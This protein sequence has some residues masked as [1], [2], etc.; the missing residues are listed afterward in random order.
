MPASPFPL[1]A[2]LQALSDF[3]LANRAVWSRTP[4]D[5]LDCWPGPLRRYLAAAGEGPR[6]ADAIL[7]AGRENER[8]L[9]GEVQAWRQEGDELT[10][11]PALPVTREPMAPRLSARIPARKWS[12]VSAFVQ[13]VLP[14]LEGLGDN[15]GRIVDGCAGKG[16]LGRTLAGVSGRKVHC[17]ERDPVLCRKAELLAESCAAPVRVACLDV[18]STELDAFLGPDVVAFLLHACGD[19]HQ[20][21]LDALR[22]GRLRAVAVAPCCF[23]R[24]QALPLRGWSETGRKTGLELHRDELTFATCRAT[25]ARAPRRERFVRR[26]AWWL[27]FEA[28]CRDSGDRPPSTLRRHMEPGRP[29]V[30]FAECARRL[31]VLAGRKAPSDTTLAAYETRGWRR[32]HRAAAFERVRDP[33]RRALE[34]WILLDRALALEESGLEVLLGEFCETNVTPRNGTI[35]AR[36]PSTPATDS[37]PLQ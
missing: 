8:D 9:P 21:F 37:L 36:W 33:F 26:E 3:L 29:S 15:A 23:F 25:V 20:Q 30:G 13:A 32:L 19:L 27:G 10:R 16:H 11:L 6:D 22:R 7:G 18:L 4:D 24:T 2:R 14:W 5:A 34:C 1:A 12:Q 35:L 17:L 28:W 31:V